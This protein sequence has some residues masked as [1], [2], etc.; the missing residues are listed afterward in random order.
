M[1]LE[2]VDVAACQAILKKGSKSFY[3]ASRLLPERLR[4][5]TAALYAFCRQMDDEVDDAPEGDA[6]HAVDALE[7]RVN[8]VYAGK[9]RNRIVD[10]AFAHVVEAHGLPKAIPLA[11]V[12]GM[13][14]DAE[15]HQYQTMADVEAY[16]LRVAGT[17]GLMMT[18]LMGERRKTMLARA[19]D[20]GVAM[21]MT[22]I[23]RDVGEDAQRGRCYLPADL[24]GREGLTQQEVLQMRALD[25]RLARAV[26]ALLAR[27]DVL[28]TQSEIGIEALPADCRLSIR[29]ARYI[30]ADI[31]LAIEKRGFDSITARAHTSFMRKVWLLCRALRP[32]RAAL[33]LAGPVEDLQV[34]QPLLAAV[35]TT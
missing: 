8:E 10:R 9:P 27:A 26:A 31:G 29:A 14:W 16:G 2:D 3:F 28:Y 5:P 32:T 34:A 11:L 19:C 15:G 24:L 1:K 6:R 12:D 18:F 13:R 21:Q 33:A 30:Y 22:N 17:V 25:P 7:A 35:E 20:L 4:G 23:A